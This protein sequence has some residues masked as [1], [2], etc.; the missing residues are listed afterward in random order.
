M[1]DNVND[2]Y[3]ACELVDDDLELLAQII[4]LI[5]AKDDKTRPNIIEKY[6][7][8]C[9]FHLLHKYTLKI[10]EM[11]IN[12]FKLIKNKAKNKLI[13]KNQEQIN[14]FDVHN[15]IIEYSETNN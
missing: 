9:K 2:F 8:E 5:R 15:I 7:D 1:Q 6:C 14:L 11:P 4:I 10:C 12:D 13:E 3:T